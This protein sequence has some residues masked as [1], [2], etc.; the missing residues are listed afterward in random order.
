MSSSVFAQRNLEESAAYLTGAT[1]QGVR[2][3]FVAEIAAQISGKAVVVA[4][5]LA[6]LANLNFAV[7]NREITQGAALLK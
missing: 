2:S 6:A 4:A 5:R 3:A 7:Q 1:Y